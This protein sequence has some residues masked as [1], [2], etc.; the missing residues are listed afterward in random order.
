V[1]GKLTLDLYTHIAWGAV[2]GKKEKVV[3][4]TR[5]NNYAMAVQYYY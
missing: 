4:I 1:V 5:T 3:G 2:D